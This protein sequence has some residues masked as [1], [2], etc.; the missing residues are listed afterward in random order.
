MFIK[1]YLCTISLFNI[2]IFS[3]NYI[4]VPFN[5]YKSKKKKNYS[6]LSS[7]I[8]DIDF[9]IEKDKLYTLLH[10]G[11]D[12]IELYLTNDY[13]NLVLGNGLCRN[14]SFS[15]YIPLNSN[16]Y[17]NL[18]DSIYRVSH[19]INASISS[20]KCLLFN[21]LN[22]NKNISI[23]NLSFLY[24]INNNKKELYNMSQICGYI[25]LQIE[26]GNESLKEY[27]FIKILKKNRII[28]SYTWSIIFLI[29]SKLS[30]YKMIG[31]NIINKY[32][33][34]L[35]SGLDDKDVK[36]IFSTEDI[37]T[38]KAKPRYSIN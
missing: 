4:I 12:I 10:L 17:K 8:K 38:I 27:N 37:R 28:S 33:G 19:I 31:K 9:F 3:K 26:S 5:S 24:G 15:T 30:D 7:N 35:L 23:N 13:F 34:F 11:N 2:I 20:D 1:I 36:L 18:T 21:N 25:G 16:F 29:N 14:N 32:D 6:N 22:L